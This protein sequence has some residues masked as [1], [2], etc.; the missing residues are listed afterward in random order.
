MPPLAKEQEEPVGHCEVMHRIMA[1][2]QQS[3]GDKFNEVSYFTLDG[4]ERKG[5]DIA[6]LQCGCGVFENLNIN[7]G[8]CQKTYDMVFKVL[9]DKS[10]QP[11]AAVPYRITLDNGRTFTGTT[12]AAG[13]TEKVAATYAAQA[14][15]EAPYY[16][17]QAPAGASCSAHECC[18]C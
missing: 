1:M 16:G 2:H 4:L 11:L 18:A 9:D 7:L 3:W 12:D 8:D 17:E 6:N 15:L 13:L 5:Q 10:G 14:R